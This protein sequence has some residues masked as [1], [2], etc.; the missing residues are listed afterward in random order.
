MSNVAIILK[1]QGDVLITMLIMLAATD[2]DE[3]RLF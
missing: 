2:R 1:I 3:Y